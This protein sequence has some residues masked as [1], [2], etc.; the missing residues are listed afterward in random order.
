MYVCMYV[1][2]YPWIYIYIHTY[3]YAY[4]GSNGGGSIHPKNYISSTTF[5]PKV[6]EYPKCQQGWEKKKK[7]RTRL[8]SLKK[9]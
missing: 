8:R 3:I 4:V 2:L 5:H 6:D 1:C 9:L 7:Q